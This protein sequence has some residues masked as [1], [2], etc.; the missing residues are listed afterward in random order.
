MVKKVSN[1]YG[2]FSA[3]LIIALSI[4]LPILSSGQDFSQSDME[5]KIKEYEDKLRKSKLSP[6]KLNIMLA[7]KEIKGW[8]GLK[9]RLNIFRDACKALYDPTVSPFNTTTAK[10]SLPDSFTATSGPSSRAGHYKIHVKEIARRDK[11][12][13]KPIKSGTKIKGSVFSVQTDKEE[14]KIDFSKGGTLKDLYDIFDKKG[15]KKVRATLTHVDAENEMLVIEGANT[16]EKYRLL[17]KGDKNFFRTIGFIKPPKKKTESFVPL[18][19]NGKEVIKGNYTIDKDVFVVEPESQILVAL[20]K[21]MKMSKTSILEAEVKVEPVK[22]AKKKKDGKLPPIG[23]IEKLDVERIK[24]FGEPLVPELKGD[25]DKKGKDK[26]D[27]KLKGPFQFLKLV[28]NKD[29][30]TKAIEILDT[31]KIWK[32]IRINLGPLLKGIPTAKKLYFENSL[33]NKSYSIRKIRIYDPV[34]DSRKGKY[35]FLEVAQD[36]QVLMNGVAIKRSKN[37]IS[38]LIR[39]VVLGLKAP[40]DRAGEL[41]IDWDYDRVIKELQKFLDEYNNVMLFLKNVMKYMPRK[42]LAILEKEEE[43][44]EKK[45]F[46]ERQFMELS[47]EAYKGLMARDFAIRTLKNRLRHGMVYS[48]YPRTVQKSIKFLVQIGF[49]NPERA[50]DA[51]SND[52]LKAGYLILDKKKLRVEL[53]SHF[54]EVKEI[55]AFAGKGSLIKNKGIAVGLVKTLDTYVKRGVRDDKGRN[56]AG[57]IPSKQK[58]LKDRVKREKRRFEVMGKRVDKKVEK[59]R[60]D[61]AKLIAAQRKAKFQSKKLDGLNPPANR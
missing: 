56:Q 49:K 53:K 34:E 31:K 24:L 50:G 7:N 8:N 16:G 54:D 61:Y 22:V 18:A 23:T 3:Y 45:G 58:I 57:F 48:P 46:D 11:I 55:F 39:G 47:G 26:K 2:L 15:N 52:N 28:A 40:S 1:K 19:S 38:D 9:L 12:A 43:N 59:V 27:K 33:K 5:K 13:T 51:L 29:R 14:V 30:M 35:N 20:S 42:T 37:E 10:S 44:F 36:A 21:P 60:R 4:V 17:L 32:K 41:E 25:E 6:I